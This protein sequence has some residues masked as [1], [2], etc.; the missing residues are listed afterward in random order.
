[1]IDVLS[2]EEKQQKKSLSRVSG[3][4]RWDI[5]KSGASNFAPVQVS[6]SKVSGIVEKGV[7][8]RVCGVVVVVDE[9]GA[10]LSW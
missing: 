10:H 3:N 5:F 4:F 1:V 9:G 8:V 6:V 7:A 2:R